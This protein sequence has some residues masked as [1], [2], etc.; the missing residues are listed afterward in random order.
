MQSATKEVYVINATTELIPEAT[1]R[2]FTNAGEN[3]IVNVSS[4]MVFN[5]TQLGKVKLY[6][7]MPFDPTDP[8]PDIRRFYVKL[9]SLDNTNWAVDDN[10]TINTKDLLESSTNNGS[11][12]S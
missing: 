2:G 11:G 9:F 1:I 10:V 6:N 5:P 7:I 12:N 3:Y 8:N 4:T